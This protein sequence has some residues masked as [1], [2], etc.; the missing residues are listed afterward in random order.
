MYLTTNQR[1]LRNEF[2]FSGIGLHSGEHVNVI[3]RPAPC[4]HGVRFVCGKIHQSIPALFD[5]VRSTLYATTL[6]DGE[7]SVGTVEHLLAAI[8]AHQIDNC[9]IE[10][11]G[12][13]I[14][15][16]NGASIIFS[17]QILDVGTVEQGSV[18]DVLTLPATSITHDHSYFTSKVNKNQLIISAG[19]KFDNL[20]QEHT[21]IVTPE[22]FHREI[23][24]C[25]TFVHKKDIDKL[26]QLG[27]IKGGSLDNAIV[28]DKGNIINP[29]HVRFSNDLARHKIL[30]IL[31]DFAL[32]GKRIVGEV[33]IYK[34]GHTSNLHFIK[35]LTTGA[36]YESER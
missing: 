25:R 11:D 12:P 4:D 26:I 16:L 19:V 20:A 3:V 35:Q 23:A 24:G 30:D 2:T 7:C 32:C 22:S 36:A 14:P 28:L 15:I 17:K 6:A 27:L 9:T 5:Y 29:E 13:E 18:A 8:F 21:C 10:V 34:P 1:T 31:G 33:S